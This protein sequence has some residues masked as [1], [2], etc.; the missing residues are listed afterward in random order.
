MSAVVCSDGCCTLVPSDGNLELRELNGSKVDLKITF[1]GGEG[2]E[3]W[4][5]AQLFRSEITSLEP[6]LVI[7]ACFV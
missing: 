5:D 6:D 3:A 2:D 1:A 4:K 7:K